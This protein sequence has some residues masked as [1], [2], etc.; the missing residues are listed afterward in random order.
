MC[1][2]NSAS[3]AQQAQAAA[4][5]QQKADIGHVIANVNSIYDSPQ[6]QQQYNDFINAVR[7]N[8]M[9]DANRQKTQADLQNKFTLARSGLA[10]GSRAVDSQQLLNTEYQK[11]ILNAENKAQGA[12]ANLKQQDNTSRLSLTQL[13]QQGLDATTAARQANASI[14]QAADQNYANSTANG[15]GDIFAQTTAAYQAAQQAQQ[16]R[17]G[18][19]TPLGTNYGANA[20][21]GSTSGGQP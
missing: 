17:L 4:D 2:N 9:Q 16:R 20:F 15:L 14:Q 3:K 7:S 10:G 11:G 6:R 13:A 5:A 12:L 19:L 21:G 8:Y 1:N 18:Y